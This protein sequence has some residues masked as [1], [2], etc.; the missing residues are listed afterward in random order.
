[1]GGRRSWVSVDA[2]AAKVV[3]E[4]LLVGTD[5]H[6]PGLRVVLTG[7]PRVAGQ[8]QDCR[9]HVV[10]TAHELGTSRAHAHPRRVAR[11]E[12]FDVRGKQVGQ[13]LR[14]VFTTNAAEVTLVNQGVRSRDLITDALSVE[15]FRHNNLRLG[16]SASIRTIRYPICLYKLG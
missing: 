13:Q 1:M 14:H 8:M 16:R 9:T 12:L 6:S 15:M 4:L 5:Q 2:Q 11:E 10:V 7:S 3:A